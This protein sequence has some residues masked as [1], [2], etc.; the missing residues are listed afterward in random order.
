MAA[1]E[2]GIVPTIQ[3]V[4]AA[5]D[6]G[7]KSDPVKIAMKARN[8]E[9]YPKRFDT[10]IM[11]IKEPKTTALIFNFGKAVITGS[12]TEE[13]AT[14]ATRKYARIIQKLG[15]P[16]TF[17]DYF[18]I[19]LEKIVQFDGE[20]SL[21]EP[22]LFPGL[23]YRMKQPKVMLLIFAPGKIVI[24]GSKKRED[25]YEAFKNIYPVLSSS[26]RNVVQTVQD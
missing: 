6:L 20:F 11:R 26:R 9:Y 14:V 2:D 13:Q 4:V 10:A 25:T 18:P 17:R 19:K 12:K 3:N 7:C 16:A 15:H 1:G 24:T 21:Y 22:E 5:V 8:A 23:V